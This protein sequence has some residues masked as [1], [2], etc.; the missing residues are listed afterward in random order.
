[1]NIKRH[2]LLH[3]TLIIL[4]MFAPL[5]GAMAAHCDMAT[6][7]DSSRHAEMMAGHDMSAMMT[8]DSGQMDMSASNCCDDISSKC[9][10]A[11][12][13][14]VNASLVLK[15]ITYSPVFEN[16]TNLVPVSSK[17]LFR[18]LTPP[19]RPPAKIS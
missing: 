19:S 16:S 15:E 10:S 17:T 7:D 5:R 1:M 13:L 11:C 14:G 2:N 6:M 4:L 12:D 8:M 3:Y 9:A 18:E